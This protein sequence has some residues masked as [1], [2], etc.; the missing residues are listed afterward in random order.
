MEQVITQNVVSSYNSWSL[1][2]VIAGEGEAS[3]GD[4]S[5]AVPGKA[6]KTKQSSDS[7][8]FYLEIA[9]VLP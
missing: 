7:S 3:A 9:S 4:F 6:F 1:S 5:G 2:R 8:I